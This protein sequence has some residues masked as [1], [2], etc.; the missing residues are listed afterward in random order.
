MINFTFEL[1]AVRPLGSVESESVF[2]GMIIHLDH[3]FCIGEMKQLSFEA[4]VQACISICGAQVSP[5][6][7]RSGHEARISVRFREGLLGPRKSF[8]RLHLHFGNLY[9]EPSFFP[10]S[11]GC[12]CS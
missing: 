2:R 10:F 5:A 1:S 4:I 6:A 9:Q 11:S 12:A 7:W 8:G 3:T